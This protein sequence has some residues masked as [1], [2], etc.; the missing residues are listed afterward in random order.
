M[1]GRA[2][3]K[4]Q[5]EEKLRR[6]KEL[7]AQAIIYDDARKVSAET[8]ANPRLEALVPYARGKKSVVIQANRKPEI[9]EA[10]KLADELK[11][12]I[13]ISGG[14]DAWKVTEELKKQDVPVIVG[15]IMTM[16]QESYDPYDAP[17]ACPAKLHE[18]GIVLHSSAGRRTRGTFP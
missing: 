16:P 12:K 10:L 2:I 3:A 5:R 15:P 9:L 6:L 11:I 1:I 13:I 18:A 8:P 14:V 7:F 17:Y 4:K